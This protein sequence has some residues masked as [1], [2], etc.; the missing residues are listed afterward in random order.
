MAKVLVESA[1]T[2]SLLLQNLLVP[3]H[4]DDVPAD[5]STLL[6]FRLAAIVIVLI[7]ILAA[8]LHKKLPNAPSRSGTPARCGDPYATSF[9]PI[10]TVA[11]V[12]IGAAYESLEVLMS[13]LPLLFMLLGFGL[14]QLDVPAKWNTTFAPMIGG[15]AFIICCL[16]WLSEGQFLH[17]AKGLLR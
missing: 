17:S 6:I 16:S 9:L 8:I 15:Y 11:T 10:V 13:Q 4:P 14:A 3:W 1:W 7:G 12:S 5:W 2:D